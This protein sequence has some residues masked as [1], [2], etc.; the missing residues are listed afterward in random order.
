MDLSPVSHDAMR[1]PAP[2]RLV[3]GAMFLALLLNLLPW[4]GYAILFH[5]DFLL[6]MLLYWS[7]HEPRHVG[8]AWGFAAGLLMDVA[9]SALLGQHALCFVVAIFLTQLLRIRMLRLTVFEQALHVLAILFVA[10]S[11]EMLLNVSLGRELPG[12]ALV[13]APLFGALLWPLTH[14][15]AT[16]PRFR[17]RSSPTIML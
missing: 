11:I 3:F 1:P 12:A 17:R 13:L 6:V 16:L 4:S 5:P 2:L 9:D 14:F 15:I 10:K 8:Q 7:V